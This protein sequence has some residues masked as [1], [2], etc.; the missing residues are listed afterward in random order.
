MAL[1]AENERYTFVDV[2]TWGENERIE[3]IDG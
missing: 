2:L 1:P 3:I